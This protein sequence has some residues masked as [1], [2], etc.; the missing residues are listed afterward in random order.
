MMIQ[1]TVQ[2]T[3]Q[4][5]ERLS[6]FEPPSTT[7]CIAGIKNIGYVLGQPLQSEFS[8]SHLLCRTSGR[9][10]RGCVKAN[11]LHRRPSGEW[12]RSD[13]PFFEFP[14]HT[15]VEFAHRCT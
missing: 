4:F 8:V 7:N 10:Q 14:E 9:A 12:V 6:R 11:S 2:K 1:R 15:L 13:E 5:T 3:E